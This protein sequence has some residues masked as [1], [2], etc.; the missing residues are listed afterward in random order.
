MV[1]TNLEIAERIHK[2]LKEI[3]DVKGIEILPNCGESVDL[4]FNVII[5]SPISW[6]LGKKIAD[7]VSEVSWKIFEETG[8]LPAVEWDVV[9]SRKD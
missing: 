3:P 9:E 5:S 8:E 1:L 2:K 6:E 4:T 7:A